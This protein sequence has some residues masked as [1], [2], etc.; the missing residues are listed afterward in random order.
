MPVRRIGRNPFTHVDV[1]VEQ[2]ADDVAILGLVESVEGLRAPRVRVRLRSPVELVLQPLPERVVRR[3]VR[4]RSRLRRHGADA[5]LSHDL[6][7]HVRMLGDVVDVD[8]IEREPDGAQ[9]GHEQRP[10]LVGP[11]HEVSVVAGDAIAIEEGPLRGDGRGVCRPCLLLRACCYD[12]QEPS[13]HDGDCEP[14]DDERPDASVHRPA[15][16]WLPEMLATQ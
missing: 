5:Q 9:L 6:F 7:P 11:A 13:G 1:Q 12:L 4:S 8:V 2:V 16:L 3:L 14:S 10:R 15:S